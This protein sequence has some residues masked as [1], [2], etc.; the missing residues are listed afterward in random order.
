[1]ELLRLAS[2]IE[3]ESIEPATRNL[4]ARARAGAARGSAADLE[5]AEA[6][7]RE[8][9][10]SANEHYRAVIDDELRDVGDRLY[11]LFSNLALET[12]LGGGDEGELFRSHL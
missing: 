11:R 12:E 3:R 9:R 6:L 10:A 1:P 7:Y 8:A 4:I 5:E 2:T